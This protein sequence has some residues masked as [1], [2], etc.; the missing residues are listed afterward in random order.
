MSIA[1]SPYVYGSKV[2]LLQRGSNL[3]SLVL[4]VFLVVNSFAS[5]KTPSQHDMLAPFHSTCHTQQFFATLCRFSFHSFSVGFDFLNC[6][7]LAFH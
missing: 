1:F 4:F 2:G 3:F 6:Y 7:A 5:V